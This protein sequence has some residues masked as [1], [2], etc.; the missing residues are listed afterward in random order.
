MGKKED[1]SYGHHVHT[2]S[3]K[4]TSKPETF[5]IEKLF[6]ATVGYGKKFSIMFSSFH[7]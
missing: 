7:A 4:F 2:Q 6:I 5:M 3:R 1:I